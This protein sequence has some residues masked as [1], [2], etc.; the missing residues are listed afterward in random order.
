MLEED[1]VYHIEVKLFSSRSLSKLKNIN[2][3]AL[4]TQGCLGN[5]DC[6]CLTSFLTFPRVMVHFLVCSNNFL[7]VFSKN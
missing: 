1:L 4:T 2:G 5:T 6:E 7:E 3:N